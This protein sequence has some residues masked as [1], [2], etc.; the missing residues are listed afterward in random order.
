MVSDASGG[1]SGS[2]NT[3]DASATSTDPMIIDSRSEG[4]SPSS[5]SSPEED[6][7]QHIPRTT[8][9]GIVNGPR[10]AVTAGVV[11]AAAAAENSER[12]NP[13]NGRTPSEEFVVVDDGEDGDDNDN[14]NENNPDRRR[15]QPRAT[16]DELE[17]IGAWTARRRENELRQRA[18]WEESLYQVPAEIKSRH[19]MMIPPPTVHATNDP[20]SRSWWQRNGEVAVLREPPTKL[21]DGTVAVNRIG[22]MAPGTSVFALGVIEL[23]SATLRRNRRLYPTPPRSSQLVSMGE[24]LPPVA[25]TGQ[26]RFPP[27]R[28]GTV[29]LI[30]VETREGRIGYACLSLDG[31]P[32]MAPGLPDRYVNPAGGGWIWRVTCPSGAYVREGLDLRTRHIQ[33]LPYGSLV[34]VKRRC[35]NLQGLSRLRTSG[36]FD[37][38]AVPGGSTGNAAGTAARVDGWCSELLNPL[39]GQRGI[40]AQPLPFPVAAIYRVTLAMGYVRVLSLID[41]LVDSDAL[42]I[43]S[44]WSLRFSSSLTKYCTFVTLWI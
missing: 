16:E 15:Q 26:Y 28:L 38:P 24:D 10:Y 40:V 13:G 35:I 22:T 30:K 25:P 31:Y 19:S 20:Q 42:S 9:A 44:R 7:F 4:S 14:D 39:S 3:N 32:L 29:Q 6:G 27:G 37:L 43:C 23:D 21:L 1:G 17:A 12:G 8:A 11:A 36:C 18:D 34:R 2:G 41:W 33:T 5:L